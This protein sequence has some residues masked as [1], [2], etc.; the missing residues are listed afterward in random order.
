[1]GVALSFYVSPDRHPTRFHQGNRYS[2][3]LLVRQRSGEDPMAM[4]LLLV[5]FLLDPV[6]GFVP[7][8]PQAPVLHPS[9]NTLIH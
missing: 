6:P 4:S 8:P 9:E 3:A 1:M 5:V 7:V 2:L